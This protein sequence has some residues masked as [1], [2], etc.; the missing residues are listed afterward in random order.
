MQIHTF[1]DIPVIS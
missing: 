1:L